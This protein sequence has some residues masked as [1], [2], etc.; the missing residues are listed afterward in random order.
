MQELLFLINTLVIFTSAL[1]FFRAKKRTKDINK[2]RKINAA[3]S[4]FV[5]FIM[6]FEGYLMGFPLMPLSVFSGIG[7]F[8]AYT[9]TRS[10]RFCTS[11]GYEHNQ[12]FLKIEYCPKCGS[13][14]ENK[15]S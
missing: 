10:T 5:S 7:L 9:A 15:P 14:I 13:K 11:C 2:K 6:F 12:P 1:I 4:L 3:A 8:M